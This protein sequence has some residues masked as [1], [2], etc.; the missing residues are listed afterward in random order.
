MERKKK[1]PIKFFVIV[2]LVSLL[3]AYLLSGAF[4]RGHGID[5]IAENFVYVFLHPLENWI[6]EYTL[7]FLG[8]TVVIWLLFVSYYLTYHRNFLPDKEYGSAEWEDPVAVSKKMAAP[9]EEDNRIF[10]ENLRV[11]LYGNAQKGT[12]LSNNNVLYVGSPG[13]G[14]TMFELTPNALLA[15][16]SMVFLDVKGELLRKYGNYLKKHGYEIR[17][18]DLKDF[19]NSD[20]YNP[21]AYIKEEAD[22]PRLVTNILNSVTPPE[23][24][25]GDPFWEDGCA[26]YLQSLFYYIWL[27]LPKPQQ[28]LNKI[29]ELANAETHPMYVYQG[30]EEFASTVEPELTYNEYQDL[31][32]T[33]PVRATLYVENPEHTELAYLMDR[34][35]ITGKHTEYGTS[36]PA[37]RDYY[38]LKGGA[39]ETVRSIILM[40]NAKLKFFEVKALKR[41]FM[42]D[43]MYLEF[44]GAGKN[45]DEKTKT[46]IFLITPENDT[47]YNFVM[48]MFYQQLFDTL[49]RIADLRYGGW[50]PIG[51]DVWMDEFANGARPERFENLINSLRSRNIAALPILQSIGQLKTI[52]KQDA[53]EQIVDGCAAMVFLGSGRGAYTTQKYISD[54]LDKTTIDKRDDSIQSGGKGGNLSF[55]KQARELMTPGEV[56]SLPLDR[57]IVFLQGHNP[58]LDYKYHPFEDENFKEAMALGPYESSAIVRELPSGDYVKLHAPAGEIDFYDIKSKAVQAFYKNAAEDSKL[59]VFRLTPED[60]KC[61]DAFEQFAFLEHMNLCAENAEKM[62]KEQFL[63]QMHRAADIVDQTKGKEIRRE[64][65]EDV[66]WESKEQKFPR[67]IAILRE[68]KLTKEQKEELLLGIKEGLTEEEI[69]TY[70]D[71]PADIQR[72]I[73]EMLKK[74]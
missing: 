40:V 16:R 7:P 66:L 1:P 32:R 46:A 63:L 25:K 39:P 44:L 8:G 19:S 21:F 65:K 58:I 27:E 28:N 23:A 12:G 18:L 47:S 69:M 49:I 22:I 61:S 4:A 68:G 34:L 26:L 9:R 3:F 59:K 35:L 31:F 67:I 33:D 41:I 37:W 70:V 17:K 71:E 48:G 57:C 15:S 36:H 30:P 20:G 43:E 24:Q 42:K 13:T 29:Q 50:L 5:R 51:V 6:S 73:R 53:W 62:E 56:G 2:L 52:Y 11:N 45:Y 14:K 10:S 55:G 38:K 60:T 72:M 74:Y 54:L 64:E